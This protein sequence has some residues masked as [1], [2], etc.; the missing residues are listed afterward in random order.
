MV[1][2]FYACNLLLAA[3][4]AA[5][6]HSAIADHLGKSAVG[7]QLVRGF[8][9]SWLTEFQIA[10]GAFLKSFSISIVY[11]AIVFL[12][13]STVLSAGAFE[14]FAQGEGARLHAF[15]RGIGKFFLRF[16]RIV[17]AASVLYFIVFWLFSLLAGGLD[18]A[19]ADSAVERWHFYLNWV[20]LALFFFAV[21]VVNI[22]VDYAKAD[23]VID[24]HG[25]ALAALGHAAGFVASHF[26]R[27]LGIYL[28]LGLLSTITIFAYSA[29]ARFFPQSSMPTILVWFLVAQALLWLRWMFR[30][31]SWGAAV[32]FYGVRP[33]GKPVEESA[34]VAQA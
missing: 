31:A 2:I 16:A 5:P 22:I 7:E 20:R 27:V 3:A 11:G 28:V 6:M 34:A 29:F 24:E 30:L 8:D 4:I 17:I 14:V 10:N 12:A 21:F 15:G 26:G 33:S 25:S 13:L 19:F 1:L 32:S 18:R 23:M 9:S